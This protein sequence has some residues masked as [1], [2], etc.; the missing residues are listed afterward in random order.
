MAKRM[1]LMLVLTLA[2]LGGVFGWWIYKGMK[3]GK[4]MAA[5]KPAPTAV[6]AAV[7]KADT[8]EP[9]LHAV[10]SLA[11]VQG[12][13]LSA[14]VAGKVVRINFESG[15]KVKK[16]DAL[17]ELSVST[18]KAQLA[19]AE[20]AMALA[21]SNFKRTNGLFEK[22]TL[23]Q[24][25]LDAADAQL[26]QAQAQAAGLKA[27]IA[28]KTIRAPFDGDLGIRL[29]NLGE[30]LKEGQ[31][32]VDL[33][34]LDPIYVNFTLPQQDVKSIK[35]QQPINLTVDAYPGETFKGKVNA[36][37]SRLDPTT[38]SLQVQATLENKDGRLR[39]GMFGSVDVL[40][41][42]QKRDVVVVPQTAI[43]YNPYGNAVYIIEPA[44]DKEGHEVKDEKGQP[45]LSVRQQFVKLGDTRGDV[46]AIEDGVKPG[47]RVVTAGQLKLR[48]G[49]EVT[50]N[51]SIAP[52]TNTAPTPPNT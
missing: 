8:W 17:V 37:D 5:Q 39:P 52:A 25:E 34:A 2:V 19:A 42:A 6:S 13:T 1:I 40:L 24:S 38:R 32:V 9:T 26:K 15:Q 30:V 35:S 23:S 47:E 46:V 20:A 7:A 44:K 16:G 29:I 31:A 21:E 28:K 36:L 3:M 51:N 50:I 48:N 12:V 11:A 18:E 45:A 27:M 49:V 4:A 22:K 43:I 41:P 10:G 33:Q 14:E